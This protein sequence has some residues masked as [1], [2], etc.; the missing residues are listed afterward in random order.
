ME[1][2]TWKSTMTKAVWIEVVDINKDKHWINDNHIEEVFEQKDGQEGENKCSVCL[3]S[4][5][6]V[7]LTM[8]AME[9]LR[10]FIPK[11]KTKNE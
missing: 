8:T 1:A 11:E 9:F 10:L 7:N 6:V 2:H 3:S 5:K 4:G